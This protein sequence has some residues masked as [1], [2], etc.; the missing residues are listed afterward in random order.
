MTIEN[1]KSPRLSKSFV[2]GFLLLSFSS[3]ISKLETDDSDFLQSFFLFQAHGN[4]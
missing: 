2:L 4:I 3:E 1:L